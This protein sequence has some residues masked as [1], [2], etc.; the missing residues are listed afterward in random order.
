MPYFFEKLK[1]I[2]TVV[3]L[4]LANRI[5]SVT[6]EDAKTFAYVDLVT[7]V[8]LNQHIP[9]QIRRISVTHFGSF[10]LGVFL[11]ST[12][13][14]NVT[15]HAEQFKHI[16][17]TVVCRLLQFPH[18]GRMFVMDHVLL[19]LK[20]QNVDDSRLRLRMLHYVFNALVDENVPFLLSRLD[21]DDECSSAIHFLSSLTFVTA[22]QILDFCTTIVSKFSLKPRRLI[23]RFAAEV[24]TADE[25]H[26]VAIDAIDKM[27]NLF[28][29]PL[30]SV[31]SSI[32]LYERNLVIREWE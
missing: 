9:V 3:Q 12:C 8:L 5:Q 27:M 20:H 11:H 19:S 25:N 26:H 14:K 24:D 18:V 28:H 17:E 23:F 31:K 21:D 15:L 6:V 29:S 13:A 2:G 30:G 7:A 4:R 10:E 1:S 16:D 22:R 32:T